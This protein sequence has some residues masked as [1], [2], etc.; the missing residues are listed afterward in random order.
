MRVD[1]ISYSNVM[2]IT[3]MTHVYLH[4]FMIGYVFSKAMLPYINTV[5]FVLVLAIVYWNPPCHYKHNKVITYLYSLIV[6]MFLV[7]VANTIINDKTQSS[8]AGCFIF[9]LSSLCIAYLLYH[10]QQVTAKQLL[11]NHTPTKE[12]LKWYQFHRN[13]RHN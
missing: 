9:I 6:S 12:P 10:F 3:S 13:R 7:S 2:N 4:I 5:F 8:F 11:L 1:S